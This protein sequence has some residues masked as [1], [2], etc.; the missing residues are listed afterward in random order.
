[1]FVGVIIRGIK[2]IK[3]ISSPIQAVIQEEEEKAKHTPATIIV[4]MVILIGT[5]KKGVPVIGV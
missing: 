2:E 1:L 3:L 4:N 5:K